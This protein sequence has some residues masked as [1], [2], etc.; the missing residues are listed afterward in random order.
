MG[1]AGFAGGGVEGGEEGEG[2]G[3]LLVGVEGAAVT[4]F[5]FGGVP[6]GVA[7]GDF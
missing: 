7:V 4:V 1:E 5:A 6:F 3:A 2:G